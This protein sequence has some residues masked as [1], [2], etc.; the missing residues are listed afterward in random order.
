VLGKDGVNVKV[1]LR[2]HLEGWDFKQIA[3]DHDLYPRVATL[4]A[5]G[6]GWVD[7]VH[8][9]EAI[10]L[11]GRGFGDIIKPIKFEGM[12]PN[13]QYLPKKKYYLGASVF[14]LKK[15][16][17]EFGD[18]WA[19]PLRISHNLLWHC[20][21]DIIAACR[22]Q[23]HGL[24]QVL[25]KMTR[26]HH[27]PVQVLIPQLSRL[28]LD[29]R[30]PTK[31]EEGSAVV[32]GHS[33]EWKYRWKEKGDEYLE[34]G[35]PPPS[36]FVPEDQDMAASAALVS[37]SSI[38]EAGIRSTDG[39]SEGEISTAAA[40]L[41]SFPLRSYPPSTYSTQSTP[42]ESSVDLTPARDT[43]P[44]MPESAHIRKSTGKR[45]RTPALSESGDDDDD[46]G[47]SQLTQPEGKRP[48]TVRHEP[49]R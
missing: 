10:T 4:Q 40:M 13:W 46:S 28:I 35:S 3:T 47:P 38:L 49:R 29:I 33:L 37:A 19:Q 31:L 24:K 48:K 9:I 22:C 34:E 14:D 16:M 21:G 8:S 42:A 5:L 1:R 32:F 2:K 36:I 45:P 43:T 26:S 17:E 30:G 39:S 11:V 18:M 7:F 41:R 6:W 15:I 25:C 27:D 12:C 20:P 23:K 44:E